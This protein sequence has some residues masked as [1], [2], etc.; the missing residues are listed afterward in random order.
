MLAAAEAGELD[1][2]DARGWLTRMAAVLRDETSGI[3]FRDL[4]GFTTTGSQLSWIPPPGEQ[5]SHLFSCASDPVET[6]Y[7]R[8]AFPAATTA[9]P[10]AAPAAAPAG[11]CAHRSRELWEEWR[12]IEP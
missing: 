6:A 4:H 7:K 8:F 1:A 10:T 12:G 9:D 3:C 11:G 2:A 5:A